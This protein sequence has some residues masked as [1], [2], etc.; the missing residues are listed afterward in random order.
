MRNVVYATTCFVNTK[1][2]VTPAKQTANDFNE[3]RGTGHDEVGRRRTAQC[4]A[5][6]RLETALGI[7]SNQCNYAVLRGAR[8]KYVHFAALPPLLFDIVADPGETANLATDPAMTPVLLECA[9]KMLDWR[10]TAGE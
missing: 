2:F 10:L 7:S 6:L 3:C 9:Q 5:D 4:A 1:S 8:Y